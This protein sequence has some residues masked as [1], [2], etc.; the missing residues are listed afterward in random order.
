MIRFVLALQFQLRCRNAR[1]INSRIISCVFALNYFVVR[2]LRFPYW[3]CNIFNLSLLIK[4]LLPN[5]ITLAISFAFLLQVNSVF[6]VSFQ[7]V[8]SAKINL[9][10][11]HARH[12]FIQ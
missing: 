6:Y 9:A 8:S 10:S 11:P 2:C 1:I 5:L 12:S 3:D 4:K 7:N